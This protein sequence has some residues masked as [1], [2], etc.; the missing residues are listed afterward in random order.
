MADYLMPGMAAAIGVGISFWLQGRRNKKI[1]AQLEPVLRA[2]GPLT[3][4]GLAEAV[5][6]NTFMGR[7]RVV[8]GLN[9]LIQA[10]KVAVTDAPPGTPQLEKVKFITYRWVQP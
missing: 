10:G 4:H 8:L 2:K 9:E 3:L 7:G 5:G 1:N 6:M